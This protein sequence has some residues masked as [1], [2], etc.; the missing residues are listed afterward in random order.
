MSVL[1]RVSVRVPASTSNLGPGFDCLGLALELHNELVLELHS[2]P[3]EPVVEV[4]GEGS[5]SL[6]RGEANLMV[7]AAKLVVGERTDRRLVFKA[8]NRIPLARG[9][10]SSAAATV[11]GLFAANR[12]L[13][14]PILPKEELFRYAWTLEGHPDN[15]APAIYGGLTV[16]VREGK[17]IR[18][19]PLRAHRDLAVVVCVPEFE[20]ATAAAR[21]VLPRTVLREDAVD[22]VARTGLLVSA[23]ERGRW[24]ALPAATL[25]RLHQP[26]RAGLVKGLAEVLR[27]AREAGECGSALSGAGPSVVAFC[28]RGPDAAR[29][30]EAMRK[31]FSRHGVKSRIMVLGVDKE[32][33]RVTR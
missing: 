18:P 25:D 10:G 21:K 20:L 1:S 19:W 26:Y 30:G 32:G 24:E 23:L 29:I 16:S 17:D 7:R 28:R 31:A 13:G 15:V 11:A 2:E 27:A 9:L 14:A 4:S 12:L 22:N 8:A 33:V 5:E 6:P 3:G